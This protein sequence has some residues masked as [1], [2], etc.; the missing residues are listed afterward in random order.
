MKET[1]I[2]NEKLNTLE[3]VL[4]RGEYVGYLIDGEDLKKEIGIK[5]IKH[6]E[7]V[8]EESIKKNDFNSYP[9]P[10]ECG[11]LIDMLIYMFN[12]SEKDLKEEKSI[13]TMILDLKNEFVVKNGKEPNLCFLTPENKRLLDCSLNKTNLTE[14]FGLKIIMADVNKVGRMERLED[15]I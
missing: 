14:I 11:F 8:K 10:L 7:K 3:D 1:N 6:F 12:I 4:K 5:W 2:K 13:S 15:L 9:N